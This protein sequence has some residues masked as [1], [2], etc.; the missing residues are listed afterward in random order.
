[1]PL[2][3]RSDLEGLQKCRCAYAS[4]AARRRGKT[5][6]VHATSFL[7]KATAMVVFARARIAAIGRTISTISSGTS[8]GKS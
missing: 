8:R 1:M 5:T 3:S 4:T 7:N 2:L 6:A